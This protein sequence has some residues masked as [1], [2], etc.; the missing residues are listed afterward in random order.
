MTALGRL[1]KGINKV[2]N[3]NLYVQNMHILNVLSCKIN[4][5]INTFGTAEI[6]GYII[7]EDYAAC[8]ELASSGK[9]F[10]LKEQINGEKKIVFS[11]IIKEF[12]LDLN[13][14]TYMVKMV[15][16]GEISKMD[17]KRQTRIFQNGSNTLNNMIQVVGGIY[18]SVFKIG[19]DFSGAIPHMIVQYEETD[20][21]FIKRISSELGGYV[22]P[23]YQA[24][25][26]RYRVGV[27]EGNTSKV[28][29]KE[30]SIKSEFAE[31]E[32]KKSNGVALSSSVDEIEYVFHSRNVYELG[33]GICFNGMNLFIYSVEGKWESEELIHYYTLRT[34]KAFTCQKTANYK[35][36]GVCFEATVSTVNHDKIAV[37]FVSEEQYGGREYNYATV[38]SSK[39]GAG[40]YCMP[41]EGDLVKIT[42]PSE[43]AD[44]S[45]AVSSVHLSMGDKD[46]DT[47]FIRNVHDKEIQFKKGELK[48]T[49]NNGLDI[50]LNDQKGIEINSNSNINITA[51]KEIT[52]ESKND[53]M[54]LEGKE[55]VEL[56]QGTSSICVAEDINMTAEQVHI[57]NM[58]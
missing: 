48:I 46:P 1:R 23:D 21:E 34:K 29:V 25:G 16:Q 22:I 5:K 38:Y 36:A 15:L 40:W 2:N 49:N 20:W 32:K 58:E 51:D 45:Y 50:I 57:Q 26:C 11:G 52:I 10:A 17:R 42:F 19:S 39:D 35:L 43:N 8:K 18:N 13:D 12:T 31:F 14:S 28:N 41:E 44:E 37:S 7:E 4:K 24:N 55:K 54:L 6:A 47:K 30:Y 53:K 9:W 27:N 56:K 3:G 33:D